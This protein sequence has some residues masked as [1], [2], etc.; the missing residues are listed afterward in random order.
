MKI[1]KNK[2]VLFILFFQVSLFA[3]GS[4]LNFIITVRC[5]ND[6]LKIDVFNYGTSQYCL[7]TPSDVDF[8]Y[9]QN[10][11]ILNFYPTYS[12]YLEDMEGRSFSVICLM[13]K[14]ESYM[15]QE[16]HKQFIIKDAFVVGK[17]KNNKIKEFGFVVG[18]PKKFEPVLQ[19][20][21]KDYRQ[22]CNLL[23][24]FKKIYVKGTENCAN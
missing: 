15:E 11:M 19:I 18:S 8:T 7:L 3:Q 9:N 12:K 13:P 5:I 14:K 4:S 1:I 24:S 10:K 23:G 6:S 22:I 16:Y 21:K 2:F 20:G 17:G